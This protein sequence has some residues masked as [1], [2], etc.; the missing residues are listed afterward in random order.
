MSILRT[1]HIIWLT[2]LFS[3]GAYAAE[4]DGVKEYPMQVKSITG[5]ENLLVCESDGRYAYDLIRR[6]GYRDHEEIQAFSKVIYAG[7]AP[8]GR[9]ILRGW[10]WSNPQRQDDD[11]YREFSIGYGGYRLFHVT[12]PFYIEDYLDHTTDSIFI[13]APSIPEDQVIADAKQILLDE[14]A[15]EHSSYTSAEP[16]FR[17]D[18]VGFNFFKLED[19]DKEFSLYE[20]DEKNSYGGEFALDIQGNRFNVFSK[21]LFFVNIC[22]NNWS[23]WSSAEVSVKGAEEATANSIAQNRVDLL[24]LYDDNDILVTY[25]I[26]KVETALPTFP[27][28]IPPEPSIPQL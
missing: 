28:I 15:R 1:I 27:K 22:E 20:P 23:P 25:V 12:L 21:S 8:W 26:R 10:F 19:S 4:N 11:E 18:G 5:E 17:S 16:Y 3:L 9:I 13:Y 6:E 2:T 7:L 14:T 24:S